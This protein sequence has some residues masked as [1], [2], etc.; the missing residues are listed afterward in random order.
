MKN[1][2]VPENWIRMPNSYPAQGKIVWT[3]IDDGNG[4]RNV[5]KLIYKDNLWWHTDMKMYVY[6][7]PTHFAYP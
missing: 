7:N 1:Q 4:V 6:Y 3:K 5:Q 2:N